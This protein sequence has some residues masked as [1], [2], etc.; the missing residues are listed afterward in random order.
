MARI[1]TYDTDAAL[2]GN[3]KL[4]GSDSDDS[5]KNYPLN[6]LALAFGLSGAV[7]NPVTLT[8]VAGVVDWTGAEGTIFE[9]D[10]TENTLINHPSAPI[11]HTILRVKV[12]QATSPYLN[13]VFWAGNYKFPA[14]LF[15]DAQSTG[16]N[17]GYDIYTFLVDNGDLVLIHHAQQLSYA[18]M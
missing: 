17:Q 14:G 7:N 13:T 10:L 11:D 15:P 9:L 4:L 18:V 12:K 2:L 16:L 1:K 3:E 8:S 6:S 5:T